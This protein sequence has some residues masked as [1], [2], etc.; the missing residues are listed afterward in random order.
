MRYLLRPTRRARARSE[1]DH[2]NQ[3]DKDFAAVL[4]TVALAS[5]NNLN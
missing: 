1:H 3:G 4:K 5:G 2:V